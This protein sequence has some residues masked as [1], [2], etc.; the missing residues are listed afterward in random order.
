MPKGDRTRSDSDQDIV[1]IR[2]REA[3]LRIHELE[4]ALVYAIAVIER[5]EFAKRTRPELVDEAV[6][7]LRKL[8]EGDRAGERPKPSS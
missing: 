1:D 6:P 3:E 2:V 8:L 4:E 5:W 7:R